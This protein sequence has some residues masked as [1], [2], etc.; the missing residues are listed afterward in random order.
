VVGEARFDVKVSACPST[1]IAT[2]RAN[3]WRGN[4]LAGLDASTE[5]SGTTSTVR[6]FSKGDRQMVQ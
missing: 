4:C 3:P 5:D 6:L 2:G 1:A